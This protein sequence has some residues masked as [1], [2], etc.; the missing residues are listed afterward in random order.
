M[1]QAAQFRI[2]ILQTTWHKSCSM[3]AVVLALVVL[4]MGLHWLPLEGGP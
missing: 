3:G 4:G 2:L 1:Q